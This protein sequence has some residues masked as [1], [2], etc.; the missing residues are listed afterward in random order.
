MAGKTK[1]QPAPP[2]TYPKPPAPKITTPSPQKLPK[3]P[4]P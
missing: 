1:T 3:L 2:G 4:R